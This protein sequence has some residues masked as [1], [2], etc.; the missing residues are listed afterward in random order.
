MSWWTDVRDAVE[1]VIGVGAPIVLSALGGPAGAA[2]GGMIADALGTPGP[3]LKDALLSDPAAAEKIKAL[4]LAKGL[5]I[6]KLDSSARLAQIELDRREVKFGLFGQWE[7]AL[8]WAC[9]LIFAEAFLVL[10]TA[11]AVASIYHVPLVGWPHYDLHTILSVLGL[12][13][14]AGGVKLVR[15]RYAK[16]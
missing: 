8:G 12:L 15:W 4:E 14:G 3:K 13:L 6:A 2:V 9:A 10:P 5:E 1:R 16:H 7:D 11:Q